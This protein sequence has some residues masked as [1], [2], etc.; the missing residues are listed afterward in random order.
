MPSN[1]DGLS[2]RAE[3]TDPAAPEADRA[4]AGIARVEEEVDH[5]WR[6][7]LAGD[8]DKVSDALV[9]ASHALARA[10]RRLERDRAIG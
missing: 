5:L 8:D 9:E 1:T 2:T 6:D 10:T 7:S 3:T 4:A